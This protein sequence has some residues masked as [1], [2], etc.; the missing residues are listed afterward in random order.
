MQRLEHGSRGDKSSNGIRHGVG[1]ETRPVV[2]CGDETAGHSGDVTEA[3]PQA[4]A[5]GAPMAGD[6]DPYPGPPRLA[7]HRAGCNAHLLECPRPRA[8][9]DDVGSR[10]DTAQRIPTVGRPQI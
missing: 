1:H 6:R 2:V 10:N 8:L 5:L 9:N 3:H 7:Q 4:R